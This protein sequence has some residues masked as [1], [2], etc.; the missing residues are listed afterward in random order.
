MRRVLGTIVRRQTPEEGLKPINLP[1][2]PTN[3]GM[4]CESCST[5]QP[6]AP[7]VFGYKRMTKCCPFF[8]RNFLQAFCLWEKDKMLTCMNHTSC[9]QIARAALH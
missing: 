3:C 9:D 4:A 8:S 1:E 5:L 6:Q 2:R 7:V